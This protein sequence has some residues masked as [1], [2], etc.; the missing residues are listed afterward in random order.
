MQKIPKHYINNIDFINTGMQFLNNIRM[1]V[2]IFR[3]SN[4]NDQTISKYELLLNYFVFNSKFDMNRLNYWI[5]RKLSLKELPYKISNNCF[6]FD[7][8]T[9]IPNGVF[10]TFYVLFD[11]PE[12]IFSKL[13][14]VN[15]MFS[16]RFYA[17]LN[18]IF[19][20][21]RDE[22]VGGYE[23]I[24]DE[25]KFKIINRSGIESSTKFKNKSLI[26]SNLITGIFI[27]VSNNV[28]DISKRNICSIL[29]TYTLYNFLHNRVDYALECYY[30]LLSL[31]YDVNE[32]ITIYDKVDRYKIRGN[33]AV[34]SFMLDKFRSIYAGAPD[35]T[36]DFIP[37]I[38]HVNSN[39][40]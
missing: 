33:H 28:T 5:N 2:E 24:I 20:E 40:Y 13:K 26:F 30:I 19:F 27:N 3:S 10:D 21:T 23:N 25:S 1:N 15:G 29:A 6:I 22:Y 37:Y 17:F 7:I 35:N 38:E 31:L 36:N 9:L 34:L 8:N 12:T 32:D 39:I 16:K 18:E 14:S 4:I 11:D